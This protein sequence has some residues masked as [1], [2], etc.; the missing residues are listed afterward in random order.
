MARTIS[1]EPFTVRTLPFAAIP[2]EVELSCVNLSQPVPAIPE[3]ISSFA[4]AVFVPMP[5]F[6]CLFRMARIVP[7]ESSHCVKFQ[8]WERAQRTISATFPAC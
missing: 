5:R 4:F 8:L 1:P 6:H 3:L 2:V 7:V